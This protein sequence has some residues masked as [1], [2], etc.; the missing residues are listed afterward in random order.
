MRVIQ[1]TEKIEL[2]TRRRISNLMKKLDE[3]KRTIE[4][5][6]LQHY[7]MQRELKAHKK[8]LSTKK[9]VMTQFDV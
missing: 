5:L 7:I 4:Q 6:Q 3:T 2:T 1:K 9:G 8:Y